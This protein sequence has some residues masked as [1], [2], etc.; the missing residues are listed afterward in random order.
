MTGARSWAVSALKSALQ[1]LTPWDRRVAVV[2]LLLAFTTL[3]ELTGEIAGAGSAPAIDRRIAAA[4]VEFRGDLLTDAVRLVTSLADTSTVQIVAVVAVAGS[5]RKRGV[6]LALPIL[7]S[8]VATTLV[9]LAMK[10]LIARERPLPP[11]SL[12]NPSTASY[13]SG[14]SAQAVGTWGA[15]IWMTFT[16]GSPK[17]KLLGAAAGFV[18]AAGVG[19]S[20]IYLGVHWASDVVAGWAVGGICLS[21]AILAHRRVQ[22]PGHP[23]G[24]EIDDHLRT[25]DCGEPADEESG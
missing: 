8:I 4:M 1:R 18:I 16:G 23:D 24:S 25:F 9:V 13:P 10:G 7:G 20:R 15:L 5:F 3:A 19:L 22:R 21:A 14:H 11:V 6:N 12:G 17:A 2:S